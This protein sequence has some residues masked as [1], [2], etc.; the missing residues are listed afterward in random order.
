MSTAGIGLTMAGRV[1]LGRVERFG[2][3]RVDISVG[4]DGRPTILK[5]SPSHLAKIKERPGRIQRTRRQ[6]A[7]TPNSNTEADGSK[8]TSSAATTRN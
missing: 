4:V 2:S 8:P 1:S 3:S 7:T 5:M 6:P